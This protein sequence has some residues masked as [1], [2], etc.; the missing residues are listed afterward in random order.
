MLN[1]VGAGGQNDAADV[2]E[3]QNLLNLVANPGLATDGVCGPA[4]IGAIQAFQRDV[5]A[6]NQP[7]GRIDP[8]GATYKALFAPVVPAMGGA[9]VMLVDL[10]H[11]NNPTSDA[12]FAA[13]KAVGV[14][15][16]ILKAFEGVKYPD[17]TFPERLLQAQNA[18]LLVGAYHFGSPDDVQTQVD[19]FC[20]YV[21]KSGGSFANI[22]AALDVEQS[23]PITIDQAEAWV[24]AFKAKTGAKPL[25]YGGNDYLGANGGANG[26]PNLA[27]CKLWVSR[28]PTVLSARPETIQGWADWTFWQYADGKIDCAYNAAL[29]GVKSDRSV[30]RGTQD[31]LATLWKG[32]L[33]LT[34]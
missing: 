20:N 14:G 15:A 33:A 32:L 2:T 4:T 26:R 25:I 28:Y 19:C 8:G 7:D 11:H 12:I 24:A 18:G 9:T 29:A 22:A 31:D 3:V 17:T 10:S 23:D 16:V 30:F 27:A 5:V 1:S 6:L 13:L 34:A 21:Q